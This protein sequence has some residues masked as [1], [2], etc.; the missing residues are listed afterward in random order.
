VADSGFTVLRTPRLLL[1]RFQPG[2][3]DAFVAYRADPEVA[4]YQGWDSPFSMIDAERF[5]E[6][7]R[8]VGF[9]QPGAW[10]QLAIVD[11]GTGLV[12]GDCA[13]HGAADRPATAEVGVTLARGS[14]GRGIATEALTAVLDELFAAR[15]MHRVVA[16]VDDRNV[17]VQRLLDRL[18]F[19]R[20]GR[21]VDAD[22]FKGEW[23]TLCSYALLDREWAA[24]VPG[25]EF[26]HH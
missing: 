24:R 5:L 8:G 17:P 2:D 7:Q 18:G 26:R 3:L 20:E 14:Q 13:V 1:R 15:G 10:L 4:R 12:H 22:W 23:T 21:L 25:Q 16:Q 9:A 19:R 6:E 11:R